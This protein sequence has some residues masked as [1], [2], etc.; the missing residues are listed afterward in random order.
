MGVWTR[1]NTEAGVAD[2]SKV[3]RK[4]SKVQIT[5]HISQLENPAINPQIQYGVDHG[6]RDGIF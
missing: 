2:F 6:A 3:R 5:T 1:V 4:T